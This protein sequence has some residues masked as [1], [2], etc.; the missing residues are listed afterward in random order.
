MNKTKAVKI[1]S[2]KAIFN[3]LNSFEDIQR[4]IDE[5]EAE[6][7][8]LECKSPRAP[9][10]D[11][12]LKSQLSQA[13]S[14]FS[15][16]GGGVIIFGVGVTKHLHSGLDILTQIEEIGSIKR[17]K[18]QI[19][20]AV[21]TLSTPNIDL[22]RSKI[23]TEKPSDTKGLIII[24][25]PPTSGDPIQ[26]DD[27][28]FYLRSRDEFVEMPY[29]TLKR[30]FTGSSG[31]DL[32]PIFDDRLVKLQKDGSWRVPIIL[33]NNSSMAAKDTEVSVTINNVSSC[34]KITGEA[35]IDQSEINP[36]RKIFMVDIRGPI[37]RGQNTIAGHLIFKMKKV[38]IAKRKL[39][40]TIEIFSMN[41]R[42]KTYSIIVQL[43]KKGLTVKKT[44]SGYLY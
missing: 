29:E 7:K 36:N 35:F 24:F 25:I 19:D 2:A 10:L 20:L 34:E 16:S 37:Y 27:D 4:L 30:M 17:F 41:M 14:G 1:E 6:N 40:L 43:T 31:P 18:Q 23:L 44:E 26:A 38:K 32:Q 3:S 28:R 42:A 21:S 12:G 22:Y 9:Q 33:E 5:G 11:R 39:D 15:N 13:I 8:Y